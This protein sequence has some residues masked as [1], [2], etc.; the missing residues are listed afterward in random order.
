MGANIFLYTVVRVTKKMLL[1]TYV[2]S[3]LT[4]SKQ[5]RHLKMYKYNMKN[6]KT[7]KQSKNSY[8]HS[9]SLQSKLYNVLFI[10]QQIWIS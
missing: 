3:F 5:L 8:L 2:N 9:F 10:S 7:K 4:V 1:L 6:F